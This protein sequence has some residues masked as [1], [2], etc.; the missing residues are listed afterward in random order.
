MVVRAARVEAVRLV[1]TLV[2]SA[3][4]IVFGDVVIVLPEMAEMARSLVGVA[5]SLKNYVSTPS[6]SRRGYTAA[7]TVA[8]N[9]EQNAAAGKGMADSTMTGGGA[10]HASASSS[11]W[12]PDPVTGYYRPGNRRKETELRETILSNEQ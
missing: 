10:S 11:S 3:A 7:A 2:D 8:I 1:T 12:M 9:A 6:V 5:A 4:V